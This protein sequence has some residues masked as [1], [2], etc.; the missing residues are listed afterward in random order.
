MHGNRLV[1]EFTK[2]AQVVESENVVHMRVRVE[3]GIKAGDILAQA[4]GAKVR[5]GIHNNRKRGHLDMDRRTETLVSRVA[6]FA[7]GAFA[8]NH[9]D[10]MRCARAE[11]CDLKFLHR[12]ESAEERGIVA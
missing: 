7:N 1:F 11:K 6:G 4:L 12:L 3:H 8:T 2:A 9:R 5:S 10:A